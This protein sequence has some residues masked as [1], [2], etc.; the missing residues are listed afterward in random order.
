MSA[1]LVLLVCPGPLVRK[2][3]V[4]LLLNPH[5]VKTYGAVAVLQGDAEKRENL[6]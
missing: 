2:E 5:P 1:A 6:K 4:V 3:D